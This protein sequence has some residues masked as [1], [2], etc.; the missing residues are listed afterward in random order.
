MSKEPSNTE[1]IETGQTVVIHVYCSD[2]YATDNTNGISQDTDISFDS[3]RTMLNVGISFKNH[4]C[5]TVVMA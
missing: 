2:C 1:E 3:Y 4:K 5:D